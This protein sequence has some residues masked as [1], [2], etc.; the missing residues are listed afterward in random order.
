MGIACEK[1]F[2]DDLLAPGCRPRSTAL[3]ADGTQK[4]I[5]TKYGLQ[6]QN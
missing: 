4:T 6:P 2:P 5:F 3:I 1:N